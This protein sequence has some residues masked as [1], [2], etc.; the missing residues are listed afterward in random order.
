M[1]QKLINCVLNQRFLKTVIEDMHVISRIKVELK[2]SNRLHCLKYVEALQERLDLEVD[3]HK[4]KAYDPEKAN[5]L[6]SAQ[7]QLLQ[8][9]AF[10]H[11]EEK[12]RDFIFVSVSTAAKMV[13][14]LEEVQQTFQEMNDDELQQFL[15]LTGISF[16]SEDTIVM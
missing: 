2:R 8:R 13:N 10:R 14:R 1:T 7:I 5:A 11:F 9:V 16:I 3:D 6:K 15:K 12:L 4:G